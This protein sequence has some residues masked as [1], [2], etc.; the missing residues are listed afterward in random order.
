MAE[1]TNGQEKQ[2]PAGVIAIHGR[3]YHTVAKRIADFRQKFKAEDGW[4]IYTEFLFRT[5]EMVIAKAIVVD[6]DGRTVAIGHAQEEIAL[7]SGGMSD[8]MLEIAETS[9]VGR[10]LAFIG[11]GGQEIASAD[12]MARR[13]VAP[14]KMSPKRHRETVESL[15]SFCESDDDQG[16]LQVWEE[17]DQEEQTYV[18]GTLRSWERA[19]IKILIQR[20]REQS[21]KPDP[22]YIEP[23][24]IKNDRAAKE[25]QRKARA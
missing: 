20:A 7:M 8:S 4:A 23:T 17:L 15:T 1:K 12:D 19:S 22:K 2:L 21:D 10:A 25:E 9:A 5:P 3:E 18:W 24:P 6:P 16:L 14:P 11:F 13:S